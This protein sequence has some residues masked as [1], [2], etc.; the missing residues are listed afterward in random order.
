MIMGGDQ[1]SR[2]AFELLDGAFGDALVNVLGV[3]EVVPRPS[4]GEVS[5]YG[6]T[7][8]G[9]A[10]SPIWRAELP[11]NLDV[12]ETK[13]S[14]AE[15]K[16]NVSKK[17]LDTLEERL[18]KAI[19]VHPT[20]AIGPSST[21]EA[22]AKPE[23]ELLAVLS[24]IQRLSSPAVSFGV[25]EMLLGGWQEASKQVA[26][27]LDRVVR[28]VACYAFVETRVQEQLLG[29]TTVSWTGDVNTVWRGGFSPEQV[30]LHQRTLA[31]ALDSRDTLLRT[32]LM[33]TQLA[34]KLSV[35]LS[36][37]GGVILALPAVWR[38]IH[39]ALNESDE[40]IK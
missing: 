30:L 23:A 7:S 19:E 40:R 15:A 38:F 36:T 31:L 37:P 25:G 9:M 5:T 10:E 26:D 39:Q 17:T 14:R 3:W 27:I 2:G 20:L 29:R 1:N 32:V 6:T 28:V 33:V 21:G 24:E 12:A 22:L 35:F 8:A 11:R 13:I 18:G 34:V 4:S 16:L